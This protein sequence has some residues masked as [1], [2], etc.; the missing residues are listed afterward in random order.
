MYF[1]LYFS[2]FSGKSVCGL[3]LCKK[4]FKL[5]NKEY[6]Q[7]SYTL[8]IPPADYIINKNVDKHVN[9]GETAEEQED[10]RHK[11]TFVPPYDDPEVLRQCIEEAIEP[12]RSGTASWPT[13]SSTPSTS[14]PTRLLGIP[15][16]P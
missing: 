8:Q 7:G 9:P 3:P 11:S 1:Q 13:S 12:V 2:T 5:F 14:K 6:M 15:F 16:P 10:R 4:L